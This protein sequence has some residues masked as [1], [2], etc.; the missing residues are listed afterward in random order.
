M[1]NAL[2]VLARDFG[3]AVNTGTAGSPVW[4][5]IAGLSSFSLSPSANDANTT[6]FDDEGWI[7][8]MKASRGGS[9][10]AEG[11]FIEDESDG[12]RDPGQEAV[13]AWAMEIGQSSLKQFRITTPGGSTL[14]WDASVV[15]PIGTGGGGGT[16]DASSWKMDVTFSGAPEIDSLGA[17]PDTPGTPTVVA[18]NDL[19]TVTWTG[20]A[21]TGGHFE[22]QSVATSDSSTIDRITST[23]PYT[24]NGL[25]N[26]ADYKVRV[27]AVSAT[28]RKSAWSALSSQFTTT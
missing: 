13:E 17:V 26:A 10:S 28:G 25:A 9:M 11:Q 19:G 22:V 27:R 15:V 14:V 3:F 18:G 5:D 2:K 7:S 1:S 12:S 8:H 21:G 16:D 6:T 4:V 23:S 20:S 24:F